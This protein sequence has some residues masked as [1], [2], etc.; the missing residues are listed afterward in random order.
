MY[1][2][3][4]C[5][6]DLCACLDLSNEVSDGGIG[7]NLEEAVASLGIAVQPALGVAHRLGALTLDHIRHYRP[8]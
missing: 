1:Y 3:M 2:K 5:Q 7:D 8:L 4:G 6:T